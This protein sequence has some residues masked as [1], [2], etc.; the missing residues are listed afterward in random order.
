[1]KRAEAPDQ[2]PH[3]AEPE[4]RRLVAELHGAEDD[5]RR[6]LAARLA[7]R[8]AWAIRSRRGALAGLRAM[9]AGPD[10]DD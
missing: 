2:G 9:F 7:W 8:P 6:E 5:T 4:V 10:G 3:I 1:M